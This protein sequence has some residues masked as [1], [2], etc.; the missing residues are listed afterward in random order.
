MLGTKQKL[1]SYLRKPEDAFGM[2]VDCADVRLPD[3][4]SSYIQETGRA[5]RDGHLSSVTLLQATTHQS[6]DTDI[7]EY[8]SNCDKC[9][10]DFLFTDMD[11]YIH[12]DMGSKCVCCVCCEH[13]CQAMHLW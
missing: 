6:V 10:R 11:N 12:N 13:L 1:Y 4:N 5:G 2:G 3:D 7:K 9:Q 8:A